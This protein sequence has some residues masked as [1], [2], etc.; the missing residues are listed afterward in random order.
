MIGTHGY[1]D[2]ELAATGQCTPK[3]DVFSVG[4]VLMELVTGVSASITD[5]H[6]AVD[7]MYSWGPW[8][9]GERKPQAILRLC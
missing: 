5:Y 4:V 2:P 1:I 3:S 7:L 9:P 6:K 8:A